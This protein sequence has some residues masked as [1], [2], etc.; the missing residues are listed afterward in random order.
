MRQQHKKIKLGLQHTYK[1]YL[2]G[3]KAVHEKMR[4]IT[5]ENPLFQGPQKYP[6]K[7]GPHFRGLE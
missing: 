2:V 7:R 4:T 1:I 6:D 5:E 3:D